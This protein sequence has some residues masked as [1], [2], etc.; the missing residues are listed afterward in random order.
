MPL[1]ETGR[2]DV[3]TLIVP[4][5]V[6][7]M[8]GIAMSIARCNA[9]RQADVIPLWAAVGNTVAIGGFDQATDW[10][11]EYVQD[12]CEYLGVPMADFHVMVNE[13]LRQE[14]NFFNSQLVEE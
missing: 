1:E 12:T 11:K 9:C 13:S 7:S 6:T 8:P 4:V 10:W 3:C 14:L 2:C 5:M